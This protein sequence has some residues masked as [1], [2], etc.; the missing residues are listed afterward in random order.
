M[1]SIFYSIL[2]TFLLFLSIKKII[3]IDSIESHLGLT[4]WHARV[5]SR[6]YKINVFDS[7]IITNKY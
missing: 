7:V 5:L 2:V 3:K 6:A 4:R 1:H